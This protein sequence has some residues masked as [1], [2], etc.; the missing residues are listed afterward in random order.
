ML[1]MAR[2]ATWLAAVFVV[3]GAA[4][5]V[6][7][8]ITNHTL[9]LTSLWAALIASF[10]TAAS[11]ATHFF[12]G[13]LMTPSRRGRLFL[14]LALVDFGSESS[15]TRRFI[16]WIPLTAIVLGAAWL[17]GALI[18]A[19]VVVAAL[20]ALEVY[21]LIDRMT[22]PLVLYLGASEAQD[23]LRSASLM[24][25]IL[26][27]RRLVTLQRPDQRAPG[28]GYARLLSYRTHDDMWT[29]MLIELFG[30]APIIAIDLRSDTK[31]VA[32][33]L[34]GVLVG[35]LG[36][37]TVVLF[38]PDQRREYELAEE[39]VTRAQGVCVT[40]FD[41]LSYVL[42]AF[43]HP[44]MPLPTVARPISYLVGDMRRENPTVDFSVLGPIPPPRG[45]TLRR[46]YV[47]R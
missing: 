27:G 41:G 31:A 36:Y 10:L 9:W 16:F 22:P 45:D 7:P 44:A 4:M 37:K 2:L 6:W 32:L 34:D 15:A 29:D 3:M 8:S 39:L 23:P 43:C 1:L 19:V 26:V 5:W 18:Y 21:Y 47:V 33:E 17:T 25:V 40:T 11:R 28:A 30:I 38:N 35:G 24:S 12:F 13:W 14:R 20:L 46:R 42:R